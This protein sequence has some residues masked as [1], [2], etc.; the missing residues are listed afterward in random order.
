VEDSEKVFWKK[1]STKRQVKILP[2]LYSNI[3][4][5]RIE[6]LRSSL[7]RIIKN[8]HEIAGG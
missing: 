6:S 2:F 4:S 8:R 3:L 5:H 1:L 7:E